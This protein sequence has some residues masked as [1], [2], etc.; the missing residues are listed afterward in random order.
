[1]GSSLRALGV[2]FTYYLKGLLKWWVLHN[3]G[4]LFFIYWHWA[5]AYLA[6]LPAD[7][8]Q[9]PGQNKTW[10]GTLLR[11][12]DDSVTVQ[13]GKKSAVSPMSFSKNL[14]TNEL[15]GPSS[16][17]NPLPDSE[18]GGGGREICSPIKV[19]DLTAQTL[20]FVT[21]RF[22]FPL[23]FS[24][25]LCTCAWTRRETLPHGLFRGNVEKISPPPCAA[26][27]TWHVRDFIAFWIH[28]CTTCCF[29]NN[30]HRLKLTTDERLR[31]QM[32]QVGVKKRLR[33]RLYRGETLS[34]LETCLTSSFET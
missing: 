20:W 10:Y 14:T 2:V 23:L 19:S 34:I 32:W 4:F 1:M 8:A 22:F 11:T 30:L 15:S 26:L 25:Y 28:S 3:N 29:A 9:P 12:K 6:H 17:Y 21:P 5:S 7:T 13:K 24:F 33:W 27:L 16:L 31:R 18:A